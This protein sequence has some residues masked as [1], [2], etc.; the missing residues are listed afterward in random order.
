MRSRG[1]VLEVKDGDFPPTEKTCSVMC[2]EYFFIKHRGE[3]RGI[4]GIFFDDLDSPSQE[5][6]FAFVRSCAK[7][8]VPCYLPI[9][10]KHLGDTFTPEE[11]G[12]QQVRRGRY[13]E[14]NLVYDRGVKFGL[15]TPGS[16]IESILMS[17][18]LTASME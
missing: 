18:P 16:R 17:L 15:A 10:R 1:K 11:K 6:V 7:T 3:T 4:G 9:V 2:D 14:F 12:W 5:E 8:V 13:V